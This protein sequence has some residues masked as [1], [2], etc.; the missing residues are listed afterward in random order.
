MATPTKKTSRSRRKAAGTSRAKQASP[1][2]KPKQAAAPAAAPEVPLRPLANSWQLARRTC[3]LLWQYRRPFGWLLLVYGIIDLLLVHGVSQFDV[4]SIK[5]TLNGSGTSSVGGGVAIYASLLGAV[6]NSSSTAAGAYQFFEAILISLVAIYLLRQV[7]VADAPARPSVKEAFYKGTYPLVPFLLVLLLVGVQF[8]PFGIGA[9]LYSTVVGGG[10]AG[11]VMEQLIFLVIFVVSAVLSIFW[12]TRSVLA[13]YIV[14]LPDV[15]PMEAFHSTKQLVR[16]RRVS[17]A[18]KL[19]FLPVA[20]FVV[21]AVIVVPCILIWAPLAQ[22]VF[23]VMT[24]L[25][26][27]VV[28][29]YLYTLYREVLD[30]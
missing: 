21:A 1:V 24:L 15:K 22:W 20:M 7:S 6:A 4:S 12:L 17:I 25:G 9:L 8:I 30:E 23:Y 26:L 5:S 11:D 18:R 28:N 27:L 29:A 10:I 3:L 16:G 14:T 2:P 13:L 19:L